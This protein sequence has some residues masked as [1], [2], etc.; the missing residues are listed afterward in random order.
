MHYICPEKSNF[1]AWRSRTVSPS[2][3][4]LNGCHY[5]FNLPFFFSL[6]ILSLISLKRGSPVQTP[7]GTLPWGLGE[8]PFRDPSF[9]P[10]EPWTDPPS[11]GHVNCGGLAKEGDRQLGR[12]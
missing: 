8:V 11:P 4:I 2:L 7:G 10:L 5:D 1:N 3:I 6:S 9:P 12:K